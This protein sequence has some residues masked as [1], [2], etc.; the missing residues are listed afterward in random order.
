MSLTQGVAGAAVLASVAVATAGSVWADPPTMSGTYT[1]TSTSP[2]WNNFVFQFTP[3]G[4]G[5]SQAQNPAQPGYGG[6]AHLSGGQWK[7]DIPN[8]LTAIG[9]PDQSTHPGTDHYLWDANTLQGQTFSTAVSDPCPNPHP[10]PEST[11][12]IPISFVSLS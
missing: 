11:V 7:L 8:D 9:C 3:C 1:L 4:P 6:R 2:Y 5:C 10:G 12:V